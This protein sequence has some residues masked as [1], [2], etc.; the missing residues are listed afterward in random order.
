MRETVELLLGFLLSPWGWLSLA[1]LAAAL[2]MLL[3]GAYLIWIAAAAFATAL[4]SALLNLSVDGQFGAFALWI[5]V[6]LLA[7]R[8]WNSGRTR[9]DDHQLL[10]QLVAQL[11]GQTAIVTEAIAGGRGRVRL[12]DSEWIA[13]GPDLPPGAQVRVIGAEGAVL[14]VEAG[15]PPAAASER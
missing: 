4:T 5:A 11:A 6:T 1:A 15:P 10:N 13:A 12:G 8:R 2:E 7:A 3:P 9:P 14:R